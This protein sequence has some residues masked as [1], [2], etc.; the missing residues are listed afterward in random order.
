MSDQDHAQ[1]TTGG[2]EPPRRVELLE[3]PRP[4][5]EAVPDL[6][7]ELDVACRERDEFKDLLLRKVAEFENYRKR[8]ERERREQGSAEVAE[9]IEALLPIL[10][11]F[12]RA[13]RA[14]GDSSRE[15]LQQGIELIYRQLVDVLAKRGLQAV[16]ALGQDFDPSLHEAVVTESS[17]NHREGEVIEV[18]RRGYR[19]G[20]QLLRPAMVKVARA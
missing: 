18:F 5:S 1:T 7:A 19:L 15:T 11:D 17:P 9:L 13:I 12:E 8:I 2:D 14:A 10:D 16:E 6:A 4:H 3:P 20:T